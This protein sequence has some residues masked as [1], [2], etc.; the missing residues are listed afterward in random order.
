MAEGQLHTNSPCTEEVAALQRS[1][2]TALII[3]D[4]GGED[5]ACSNLRGPTSAP[6]K[7][8]YLAA[9]P[10]LE[11]ILAR[12][13]DRAD[14]SSH[15]GVVDVNTAARDT[16]SAP[17][18]STRTGPAHDVWYTPIDAVTAVDRILSATTA[19]IDRLAEDT[20][21]GELRVCLDGLTPLVHLWSADEMDAFLDGFLAKIKEV[22]AVGHVHV[23][24]FLDL[25]VV[26]SILPKFDVLLRLRESP[27]GE[28]EQR[29][30]FT[31][32]NYRTDWFRLD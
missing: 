11:D 13:G 10:N 14:S 31:D 22:D 2:C 6:H 25:D 17:Q 12:H 29:W 15:F 27:G 4:G 18:P 20:D 23:T 7:H 1:G 30:C 24:S 5:Q 16:L 3:S 28:V 9:Y 32:T 19:Q 8:L 26:E 21:P